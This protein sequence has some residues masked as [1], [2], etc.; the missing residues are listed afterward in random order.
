M[1]LTEDKKSSYKGFIFA[2]VG[3]G[4]LLFVLYFNLSKPN[5]EITDLYTDST[6]MGKF[7]FV[8]A[9]TETY[10]AN[11]LM[12]WAQDLKHSGGFLEMPDKTKPSLLTV[13]FYKTSDTT[14]I[15][16]ELASSLK[17]QF[18]N[19]P[20]IINKVNFVLNGMQYIGH[21]DKT[22]TSMAMDSI[23]KTMVFVPK[24]GMKAIDILKKIPGR[25]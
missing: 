18:P 1:N 15:D 8:F 3:V 14:K 17:K 12:N 13:Y 5:I 25:T 11:T 2:G 22:L 7:V 16:T 9:E 6:S 24:P 20:E 19:N 23:F 10:E 4:L 21:N